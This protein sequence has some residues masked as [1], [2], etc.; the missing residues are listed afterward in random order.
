MSAMPLLGGVAPDLESEGL[1]G[2]V[3]SVITYAA[4]VE[5]DDGKH[6]VQKR[7][8]ESEEH[9]DIAGRQT[10]Y[11]YFSDGQILYK[12]DHRYDWAG[13]LFETQT[14]HSPHTNLCDTKKLHYD[15][16]KLTHEECFA[17]GG[18]LVGMRIF[19]YGPNGLLIEQES[20]SGGGERKYY[21]D[22]I[23]KFAYDDLGREIERANWKVEA[24]VLTPEDFRLGYYKTVTR[25]DERG[26]AYERI[27]YSVDDTIYLRSF[28]L[29]DERGNE[30]ESVELYP[31]GKIK[32]GNR[33][34][35][36][37]DRHGNWIKETDLELEEV[38][39]GFRY[40]P[41]EILYRKIKYY[42]DKEMTQGKR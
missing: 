34:L 13:K 28:S 41:V 6:K 9:Y 15:I 37:Y 4:E 25:Y 32:G 39:G 18:K 33:Y 11:T 26:R 8:I 38:D 1:K 40:L 24:G 10:S 7:E 16:G 36:E 2:S 31:D 22:F 14:Q 19:R 23:T 20:R 42:S 30:L 17:E 27:N 35:Y 12:H 3:K 21:N 5:F 29:Y